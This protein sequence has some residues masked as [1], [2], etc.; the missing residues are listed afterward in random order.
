MR[1]H[2]ARPVVQG[3]ERAAPAPARRAAR[4]DAAIRWPQGKRFAFTVIDDTDVGTV[5]NL[6][7]MYRLLEQLGLN[8]TKTVW[9]VGCPEGSR[10]YASSQT[11]DD[12]QY[13]AFVQDLQ[14]RG[15][16]IAFHGATMETSARARTLEALERFKASFGG[17]PRVHANHAFNRENMYWGVDRIDNPLVKWVYARANKVAGDYYTGHRPGAEHWWG[18]LCAERIEYVRNLTYNALDLS[19]INPSMP[20]RDPRRPLVNWWYSAAD[21]DNVYEFHHLLSSANQQALEQNGG[22]TIVATHF[23]KEYVQNGAVEPRA[24]ALLEELSRRDGWFCTVGE[25]LDWL[26]AQRQEA[27]LPAREWSR[28]QWL[29]LRDL[30]VR[31]LPK[32]RVRFR[33]NA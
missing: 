10:D 25:L 23:G 27:E 32:A 12:P 28:M 24:R 33:Q 20:Y 4:S 26:R 19:G 17:Y 8:A 14:R 15:F 21:A 5:A 29:W 13:L 11:L 9:P 1:A 30:I 22:F 31:R 7:P 16:E 3:F 18:D 6:E 2:P